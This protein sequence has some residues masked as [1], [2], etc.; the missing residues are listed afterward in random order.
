M[1]DPIALLFASRRR[2]LLARAR[3]AFD[4]YRQLP[5]ASRLD[6]LSKALRNLA[7]FEKTYAKRLPEPDDDAA[8]VI[9]AAAGWAGNLLPWS[10]VAGALASAFA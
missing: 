9:T 7:R 10:E 8:R 3:R 6:R 2:N 4:A 1:P 5:D